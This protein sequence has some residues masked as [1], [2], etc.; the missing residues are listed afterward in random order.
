MASKRKVTEFQNVAQASLPVTLTEPLV[1]HAGRYQE[2]WIVALVLSGFMVSACELKQEYRPVNISD[3]VNRVRQK[4]Q[5][6]KRLAVF[7]VRYR[8]GDIVEFGLKGEVSSQAAKDELFAELKKDFPNR[9]FKDEIVVLPGPD[10][11][12]EPFGIV[13]NSV[14]G[15]YRESRYASELVN[16]ALMGTP[17]RL[18]K[19]SEGWFLVQM[20][21]GYLGWMPG[22]YFVRGSEEWLKAWQ[23]KPKVVVDRLFD[24]IHSRPSMDSPVLS[25]VVRGCLLAKIGT[26]DGWGEVETPDGRRGF[27]ESKAV[28]EESALTA[29]KAGATD[30]EATAQSMLGFPYVWGGTSTKG[31]DC[32]GFTLLV[33]RFNNLVLP[34]DAD[35]QSNAGQPVDIKAGI[36]P[37]QKGDLLFFGA[38]EEKITHVGIYL[39]EGRFIH[40][41]GCVKINSLKEGDADYSAERRA[42]LRQARRFL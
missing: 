24:I 12:N 18:L 8:G 3:V 20:P 35:M 11:G 21:D 38:S 17:L 27:L 4:H 13:R 16:Q 2:R 25:D 7:Q 36:D 40:S 30:L 22:G 26:K 19:K 39:G 29:K 9:S 10:L 31:M 15:Q 42:S 5:P 34:R 6:D 23:A 1:R 33:F 41:S 32:S 14:A 37:L 28:I